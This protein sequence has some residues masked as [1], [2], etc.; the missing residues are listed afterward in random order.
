MKLIYG[1]SS[2]DA[3]QWHQ[4]RRECVTATDVA[5]LA[6][7]GAVVWAQL[8]QEKQQGPK[9]RGNRYTQHGQEREPVIAERYTGDGWVHNTHLFHSPA[10]DVY[11]AT[12]DL[13]NEAGEAVADIKTAKRK[14]DWEQPQ[15][16]IDQ[17][18]WQMFVTGAEVGYIFTEFYTEENGIMW[19]EPDIH[20]HRVERDDDRIEFLKNLADKFWEQTQS[21]LDLLIADYVTESANYRV[22]KKQKDKV[23]DRIKKEAKAQGAPFKYVSEVGSVS[24]VKA[25]PTE[26]FDWKKMWAE[27]PELHD[28][29]D[30]YKSTVEK[31]PTLRVTPAKEK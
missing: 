5:R 18:L 15:R 1:P 3:E 21:H 26:E 31:E 7:G 24:Y 4:A 13:I 16:Y 28:L 10:G 30:G 14:D 25:K 9:F 8:R 19:P 29:M 23:Y 11:A 17:V 20:E 6:G 22:A 2:V 27:H 12:P